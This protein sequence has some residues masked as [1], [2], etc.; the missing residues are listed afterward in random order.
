MKTFINKLIV[1]ADGLDN[2]NLKKDADKID[3]LISRASGGEDF[4]DLMKLFDEPLTFEDREDRGPGG[5][6][7]EILDEEL[8]MLAPDEHTVEKKGPDRLEELKRRNELLKLKR[9][10]EADEEADEEEPQDDV[11]LP[12]AGP[13]DEAFEDEDEEDDADDGLLDTLKEKL[14]DAPD[15]AKQLLMLVKD[16]PELLELLAL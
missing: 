15:L 4:E 11:E 8:P 13:E 10:L 6:R 16:N 1:L 3:Q 12:V 9:S 5:M 2:L 14:K 7:V